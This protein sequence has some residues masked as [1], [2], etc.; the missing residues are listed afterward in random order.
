[1]HAEYG[2]VDEAWRLFERW[3]ERDGDGFELIEYFSTHPRAD[4][5]IEQLVLQA[6]QAGWP[7]RGEIT[8][9]RW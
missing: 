1:M 8:P 4:D 5:R 6:E 3:D 2:H 7:L 9:L